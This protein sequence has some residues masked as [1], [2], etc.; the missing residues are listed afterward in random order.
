MKYLMAVLIILSTVS[1]RLREESSEETKNLFIKKFRLTKLPH[2]PDDWPD[3][4]FLGAM[5]L[6]SKRLEYA[7]NFIFME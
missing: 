5:D 1:C 7:C 3:E 2:C 6:N 4:A